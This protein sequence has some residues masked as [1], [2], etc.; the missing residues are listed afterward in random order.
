M[1]TLTDINVRKL[2]ASD[3]CVCGI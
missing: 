1:L 3:I 2:K